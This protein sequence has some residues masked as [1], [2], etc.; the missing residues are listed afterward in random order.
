ML[1][2]QASC[3]ILYSMITDLL[4]IA[5]MEEGSLH[6]ITEKLN[7]HEFINETVTHL[8]G[9]A[10]GKSID[11]LKSGPPSEDTCFDADKGLLIRVMH[12][13]LTNAIHHSGEGRQIEVGY[14]L[15]DPGHIRVFVKD[16]GPG[17]PE[18][19]QSSIF[20][21]F[22]QLQRKKDGRRFT[23]GLGLTYCKM[24]V[25][26]HGGSIWVDSDGENGSTFIFSLPL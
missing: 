19:Y 10:R 21:K 23:T 24:A 15:D 4:D 13:L 22:V 25:E 20:E 17:V 7:P 2:G 18:E 11:I 16:S 1:H 8:T 5:R 26:L 3:D 6:M 12:N 9:L 14:T